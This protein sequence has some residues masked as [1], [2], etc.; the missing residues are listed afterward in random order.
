MVGRYAFPRRTVGTSEKLVLNMLAELSTREIS[1]VTDPDSF[2]K[3][4]QVARQGGEVARNAR[5]ELEAKTGKKVVSSLNAKDA[6]MLHLHDQG[7]EDSHE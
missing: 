4:K 6:S 7:Q 2:Q 3:H 5:L 1:E